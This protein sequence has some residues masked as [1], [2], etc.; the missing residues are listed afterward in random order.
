M[1]EGNQPAANVM[2]PR[3]RLHADQAAGKIGEPPFDLTSGYLLPQND[4]TPL[5]ETDDMKR[6][7]AEIDPDRGD[8]C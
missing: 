2:R 5:V 1:A 7:F 8:G 4:G 3:A 6:V